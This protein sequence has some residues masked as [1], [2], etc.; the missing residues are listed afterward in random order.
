MKTSKLLEKDIKINSVRE[1]KRIYFLFPVYLVGGGETYACRMMEYLL[2]YTGVKIGVIDFKDGMLTRTCKKFFADEDI[3]YV[4]Y[5]ETSWILDDNS[6]IFAGAD[7]LGSIKPIVGKNIRIKVILLEGITGW[8][9]LFESGMV[10]KIGKLLNKTNA[11]CFIDKGCYVAGCKQLKQSFRESYVPL[12]FYTEQYKSYKKETSNN[13]I[14]LVWL[15]RF[16]GSKEFSIYNIIENFSK[17]VTI[18]KKVFHLIGNGPVEDRIKQYAEK[19][20][21]DI[22]FIFPGVMTG[23]CLSTYIQKKADIGIAMGT[24]TLNIGALGIPVILAHQSAK[25]F[26]TDKFLWL[27]DMYGYCAGTPMEDDK[28]LP[29]NFKGLSTFEEMLNEVCEKGQ[30]EIIGK[31][32]Q[33]FYEQ[34][35][36]SL[37][38]IGVQFMQA[39]EQTTLTYEQLKKTL[40]FLPYNDIN[41]LAV[42]TVRFLGIPFFKSKYFGNK[43]RYYLFGLPV[44]KIVSS[45]VRTKVY[46][47]GIKLFDAFWWGRYGYWEAV[48]PKVKEECKDKYAITDRILK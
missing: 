13:E 4:D 17:Y 29:S 30:R 34:T 27:K 18:K 42:H 24:S 43:I 5:E 28:I 8:S 26:F 11:I 37:K 47:L 12:F 25:Y 46:L 44:M 21:K 1:P 38:D 41:G 15:G 19:Y 33:Q 23:E 10:E 35:F 36:G 45:S 39:V 2:T 31:Q 9:S 14:N 48:N 32:C 3:H 6:I 7:H 40:K 22:Q 16:A 20:S